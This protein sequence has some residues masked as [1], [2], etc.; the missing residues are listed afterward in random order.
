MSPSMTLSSIIP[1]RDLYS[2]Y[3]RS[4][5]IIHVEIIL[6]PVLEDPQKL[7]DNGLAQTA[8]IGTAVLQTTDRNCADIESLK[9]EAGIWP[10]L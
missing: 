7:I 8:A 1:V 9:R 2:A 5:N 3:N 6:E 10:K 4:R